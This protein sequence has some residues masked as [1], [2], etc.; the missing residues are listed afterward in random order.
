MTDTILRNIAKDFKLPS[1][2]LVKFKNEEISL[3]NFTRCF[4]DYLCLVYKLNTPMS[5]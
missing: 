4:H 1:K 5:S 3:S 2:H